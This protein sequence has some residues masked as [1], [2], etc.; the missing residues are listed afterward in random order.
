MKAVADGDTGC[1]I[2]VDL[3]EGAALRPFVDRY[4][5]GTVL[6][7]AFACVGSGVALYELSSETLML[8]L[9]LR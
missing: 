6:L 7:Y 9:S 3:M 2:G 8:G 4:P 5:A 1:I